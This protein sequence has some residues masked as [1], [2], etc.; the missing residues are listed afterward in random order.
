MTTGF[1]VVFAWHS[2]IALAPRKLRKTEAGV[3]TPRY[4]LPRRYDFQ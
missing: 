2:E 3:S 4:I 1:S